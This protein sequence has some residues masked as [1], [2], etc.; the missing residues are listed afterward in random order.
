MRR[1]CSRKG[2][3]SG[4]RQSSHEGEK[5]RHL[6]GNN[7]PSAGEF[8]ENERKCEKWKDGMMT[9]EE[10]ENELST[11]QHIKALSC[12]ILTLSHT[13]IPSMPQTNE[14]SASQL[15]QYTCT[16][17]QPLWG[18]CMGQR[19]IAP[20]TI[21]ISILCY[22]NLQLP[23]SPITAHQLFFF[24]QSLYLCCT[25]FQFVNGFFLL[26]LTPTLAH[27]FGNISGTS[28]VLISATCLLVLLKQAECSLWQNL[29]LFNQ[30]MS[31]Q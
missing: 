28:W 3:D 1:R 18:C 16:V 8:I 31:F 26:Q 29:K 5:W 19:F 13:L 30:I 23:H 11:C 27:R 25:I 6:K 9:R 7:N 17:T 12:Y 22:G 4:S 20:Y 2:T 21:S 24:I 14:P 10:Q 15:L